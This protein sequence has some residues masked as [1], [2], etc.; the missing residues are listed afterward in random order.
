MGCAMLLGWCL[1][2]IGIPLGIAGVVLSALGLRSTKRGFAIAGLV[3]CILG[4]LLAVANAAIG[5]WMAL[6]GEH[7]VVNFLNP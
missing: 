1:P 7:W 2:C 4:L 6:N 3:L 5:A